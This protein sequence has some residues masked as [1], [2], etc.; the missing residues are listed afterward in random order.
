[1]VAG[2]GP[3]VYVA[4]VIDNWVNDET[5]KPQNP[6]STVS[7]RIHTYDIQVA[8]G[9]LWVLPQSGAN[10]WLEASLH[11]PDVDTEIM[12]D[13]SYMG[14]NMPWGWGRVSSAPSIK[15]GY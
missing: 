1:M 15:Y 8:A 3:A 13:A 5:P 14:A 12:N 2:S 11:K 7:R 10:G 4:A 9:L 6:T